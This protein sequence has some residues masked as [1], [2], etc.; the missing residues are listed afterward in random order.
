MPVKGKKITMQRGKVR[1]LIHGEHEQERDDAVSARRRS[2]SGISVRL[3]MYANVD[4][5]FWMLIAEEEVPTT[6]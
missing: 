2:Q 5:F 4:A 6:P 3:N 1:F